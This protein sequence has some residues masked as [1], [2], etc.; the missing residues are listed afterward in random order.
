[1]NRILAGI[2]LVALASSSAASL[3]DCKGVSF[4]W[5]DD[6]EK[7]KEKCEPL[8]KAGNGEAAYALFSAI[9]NNARNVN[10]EDIA[11]K[12]EAVKWLKIS[13]ESGYSP[14]QIMLAIFYEDGEFNVFKDKAKALSW[15]KAAA[16]SGD[17]DAQ[18]KLGVKYSNGEGVLQDYK[19]AL[20]WFRKAAFNGEIT[21]QYNLGIM[22]AQGEGTDIDLVKAYAW[23][24]IAATD[25]ANSR[26]NYPQE[27]IDR[28]RSFRDE[29]LERM[30]RSQRDRGQKLSAE[31]NASVKHQP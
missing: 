23:L 14:A 18:F 17:S 21:A 22:Y 20:F 2:F 1:M 3:D 13:A 25:I 10:T 11:L 15:Y 30:N 7:V 28:Y 6:L 26:L 16:N 5:R 12:S 8:A 19:S 29:V 27:N 24:N 31:L 9:S 4:Y